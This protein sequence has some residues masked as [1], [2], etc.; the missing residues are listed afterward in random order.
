MSAL[1]L[2]ICV[3]SFSW[4]IWHKAKQ[5]RLDR[6]LLVAVDRSDAVAALAVLK[7]GA[8]PNISQF[9]ARRSFWE[10]LEDVLKEKH[11]QAVPVPAPLFKVLSWRTNRYGEQ[12]PPPRNEALVRILVEYG[13]HL[14]AKGADGE[15]PLSFAAWTGDLE[16]VRLLLSRGANRNARDDIGDTPLMLSVSTEN[17]EIVRFLVSQNVDLNVRTTAGE[18]AL[19]F[20]ER[21]TSSQIVSILIKA[22]AHR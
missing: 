2:G 20:A 7:E 10:A 22:G 17:T 13:A 8:D 12:E 19:V 1:L 6:E 16:S 11:Y 9:I 15:T 3:V 4:A 21:G 14:D 5:Q 18:T